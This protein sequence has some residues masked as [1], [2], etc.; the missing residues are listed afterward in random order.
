MAQNLVVIYPNRNGQIGSSLPKI[1][2][3]IGRSAPDKVMIVGLPN[4]EAHTL[5]AS[6]EDSGIPVEVKPHLTCEEDQQL[7][8]TYNVTS[9]VAT[10]A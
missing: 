5:I 8:M 1:M 2:Q 7:A 4:A 9:Y 10:A 3:E 6:F